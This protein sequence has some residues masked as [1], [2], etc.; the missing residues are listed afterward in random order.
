MLKDESFVGPTARYW[1]SFIE[2]MDILFAF[3][4]SVKIGDWNSHLTTT[5]MMLPC[6]FAYDRPN[7]SR[8]GTL[9]LADMLKLPQSHPSIHQEF[10]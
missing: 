9:Y 1:F 2:M 3:L 8:F 4:R 5:R 10:M 6:F 7:Y